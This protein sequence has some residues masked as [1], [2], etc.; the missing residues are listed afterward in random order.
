MPSATKTKQKYKIPCSCV[1]LFRQG[2]ILLLKKRKTQ[3]WEVPG[4]KQDLTDLTLRHCAVRELEEETGVSLGTQD[5]IPTITWENT[6]ETAETTVCVTQVY[7]ARM[8][9]V[10]TPRL[11]E[12]NKFDEWAWVPPHKLFELPLRRSVKSMFTKLAVAHPYLF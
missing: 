9:A 7:L 3:R 12:P 10:C 5:L 11:A 2:Q 4:G 1:L 6:P 8:R